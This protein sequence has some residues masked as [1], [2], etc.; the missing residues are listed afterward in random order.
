ML[1]YIK[2]NRKASREAEIESHGKSI[3]PSRVQISKRVYSRSKMKADVKR[4]L[5]SDFLTQ[6]YLKN[7]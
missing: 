3:N 1:D 7:A 6:L 4:H 5:P 2:V